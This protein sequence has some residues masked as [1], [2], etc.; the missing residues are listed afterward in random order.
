MIEGRSLERNP[1][2]NYRLMH[3]PATMILVRYPSE[4]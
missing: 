3:L 1:S 4:F 2:H